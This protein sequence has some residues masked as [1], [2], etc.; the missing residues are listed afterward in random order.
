MLAPATLAL[1]LAGQIEATE[2]LRIEAGQ[3]LFVKDSFSLPEE[4]FDGVPRDIRGPRGVSVAPWVEVVA[5]DG[6]RTTVIYAIAAERSRQPGTEILEAT[7]VLR[8]RRGAPVGR[9]SIAHELRIRSPSVT[10][11]EIAAARD[12]Y[13]EHLE[14]ATQAFARLE[15][16][17]DHL[18]PDRFV[19]P[20][21]T[22]RVP[23]DRLDAYRSF[24]HHRLRADAAR[25][26]IRTAADAGDEALET[27]AIKALGSLSSGPT[28]PAKKAR[29][30]EGLDTQA[31]LGKAR[32]ALADL[33]LDEAEG[34]L[35]K[36]RKTRA[37]EKTELAQVLVMEGA[38]RYARDRE[39][40]AGVLFGQAL[41]AEPGL[42]PK[43]TRSPFLKAFEAARAAGAC[44]SPTRI[45]EVSVV[46]DRTEAG[47][48]YRV[49]ARYGPDPFGL[50]RAGDLQI[51]GSG[52]GM[53]EGRRAEAS[54]GLEE[55]SLVTEIPDTGNMETYAGQIL[56]KVFLRDASGVIIDSLGDPD[57]V[58]LPIQEGENLSDFS[59][60]WWVWAIAGTVAVAGAATATALLVGKNDGEPP[61]GI[62]PIEVS[63]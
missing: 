13:L 52:G 6:G 63:F 32:A 53:F 31:A 2:T 62:G 18:R 41:C 39:E 20:P 37:L 56:V 16:L 27:K 38:L 36:L 50:V 57:P 22:N 55:T 35:D 23:D 59:I 40:A 14:Q 47:L 24:M 21:P 10:A 7:L 30:I 29:A 8:N 19:R 33:R 54:P 34:F 25:D 60:P 3:T 12:T 58:A 1:L 42:E 5:Q 9:R 46:R 4:V 44:E 48:V 26:R 17:H 61:L 11:E 49:I 28:G 15:P 43:L 45:Q 51:W